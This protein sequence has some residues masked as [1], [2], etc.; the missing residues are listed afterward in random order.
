MWLTLALAAVVGF[1]VI[2]A[3]AAAHF[4]RPTRPAPKGKAK[5]KDDPRP[6]GCTLVG[7][8]R[9]DRLRGS[10]RRD[11][12]CG[13]GGNDRISGRGGNDVLIGGRGRDR[14]DGGPGR[15][16]IDARDGRHDRV[17]G[18]RGRDRA[19]L[20][21]A[22][23]ARSIESGRRLGRR[24]ARAHASS[25]IPY[26][27]PGWGS[28]FRD[29]V[30][31]IIHT[32]HPEIYSHLDGGYVAVR[33]IVW[34]WSGS[35]WVPDYIGP[36]FWGVGSSSRSPNSWVD[37]SSGAVMS[38]RVGMRANHHYAYTITIDFHWYETGFSDRHTVGGLNAGS[39]CYFP[40]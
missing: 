2:A 37:S 24:R 22:D 18:G 19:L 38:P 14:L 15:D 21:R 26:H 16:R 33:P 17:N 32:P 36:W 39:W 13:L 4:T 12:I 40:H 34:F 23:R 6:R 5:P 28:C 31:P 9:N 1:A 29:H 3:P 20:D 11:V 7:T 10:R 25:H 27:H 35:S 30:G 8:R